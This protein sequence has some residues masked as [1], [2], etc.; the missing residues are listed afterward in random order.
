ME[1]IGV[2]NSSCDMFR[3][4]YTDSSPKGW[5]FGILLAITTQCV[6]FGLAGLTHKFLVEPASMIWPQNLVSCAFMCK[7]FSSHLRADGLD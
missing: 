2:S 7:F 1:S 3:S 5:G 4:P 6:G